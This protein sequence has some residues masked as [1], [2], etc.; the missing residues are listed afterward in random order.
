MV[1]S[2]TENIDFLYQIFFY[3][4]EVLHGGRH[5]NYGCKIDKI[6]KKKYKGKNPMPRFDTQILTALLG[7]STNDVTVLGGGSVICDMPYDFWV[8]PKEKT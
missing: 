7:P 8:V 4:A 2:K 3:N 6:N 1:F 5:L